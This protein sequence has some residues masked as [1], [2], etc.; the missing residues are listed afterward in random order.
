MARD[1][2]GWIGKKARER[3]RAGL[4]ALLYTGVEKRFLE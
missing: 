4:P 3:R 2:K 1:V